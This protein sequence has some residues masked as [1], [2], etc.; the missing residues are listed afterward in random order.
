MGTSESRQRVRKSPPKSR[1]TVFR[2]QNAVDR[3]EDK[4][5]TSLARQH[6]ALETKTREE[7][8]GGGPALLRGGSSPGE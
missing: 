7:D 4:P 1:C 5:R 3:R 8:E 6:E 2:V